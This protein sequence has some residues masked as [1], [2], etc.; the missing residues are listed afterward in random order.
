MKDNELTRRTAVGLA[1]GAALSLAAGESWVFAAREG[2]VVKTPGDAAAW[3]PVLL[4]QREAEGLARLVDALIPRTATPG[5]RDARVH[6]YIDLAVSLEPVEEKK[7]FV[8]G[9]RWLD[10]RCQRTHGT[11]LATAEPADLV[12]LLH[13]VSDEHEDPPKSLLPGTR[14]FADLKRRTIFGYYTSLEGRVQE[15]GLPEAVSLQTWRGCPH[16]GGQHST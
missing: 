3:R 5:A 10:R 8:D 4:D 9:L 14:F 2:D 1:T 6:E 7:A 13:T 11:D 12:A 15:L 16:P